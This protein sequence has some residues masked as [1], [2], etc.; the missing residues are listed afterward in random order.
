MTALEDQRNRSQIADMR[1]PLKA[2]TVKVGLTHEHVIN[3]TN[4]SRK[5]W[6]RHHRGH[7]PLQQLDCCTLAAEYGNNLSVLHQRTSAASEVVSF[8]RTSS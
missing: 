3:Y 7:L 4:Y 5:I 8:V 2:G 1:C 6:L